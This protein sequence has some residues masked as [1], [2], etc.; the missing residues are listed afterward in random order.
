[1]SERI[2][3]E[4]LL[5]AWY[6]AMSRAEMLEGTHGTLPDLEAAR[7]ALDAYHARL[8]AERDRY[9]EAMVE[10]RAGLEFAVSRACGCDGDFRCAPHLALAAARRALEGTRAEAPREDN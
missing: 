6:E 10:A 9:R 4:R 7:A 2:E 3:W 1:M 8:L 5:L